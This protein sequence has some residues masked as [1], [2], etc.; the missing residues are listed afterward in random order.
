MNRNAKSSTAFLNRQNISS[1]YKNYLELARRYIFNIKLY[2]FLGIVFIHL[3][4]TPI[5]IDCSLF[6]EVLNNISENLG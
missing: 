4:V 2:Q 5:Q 3:A 6:I 1:F